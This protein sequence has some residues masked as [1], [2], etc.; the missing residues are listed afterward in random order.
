MKRKII[1]GIAATAALL[2][3]ACAGGGGDE[4][5]TI[6][7]GGIAGTTGAYGTTGQAAFNGAQMAI[8]E[9]NEAGGIMGKQVRFDGHDDGA[10]ATKASQLFNKLQSDGAV[11]IL[12][13]PDQGPTIAALADQ[14][15]F[16]ALGPVDNAGLSVY[17]DGPEEPPYAWAW[18][19]GLNTFA[20]GEK[21]GQYALENCPGGLAMLHDTSG[22]G[23]GGLAGVMLA[24]DAAG[25]ELALAEPITE[26]WSTGATV[27]L[28]AEIQKIK[29]SGA[30]CVDVWLTPQD[31]AAFLQ[32]AAA[33]GAEFTF[34]G[35]DETCLDPT[36]SDLA[37]EQGDGMICAMLTSDLDPSERLTQ[38]REDYKA[39]FDVDATTFS[40]LTYDS[41]YILKEAIEAGQS[42]EPEDLRTQLNQITDFDGLTGSLTFSEQQHATISID[43]LTVVRYDAAANEWVAV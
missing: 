27:G 35:N 15:Q 34:I 42:T 9:I 38:F 23:M 28:K 30:D 20:W 41:V 17:P 31:Q 33:E 29:A 25:E 12:G 7:V 37:K 40:A 26:N 21:L 5:D 14:K 13:S 1:V 22:Y 39:Q 36:F 2:L 16:P 19:T 43:Q 32:E 4:A 8:D 3:T 24:Y 10:D 6:L 18:S 11:V